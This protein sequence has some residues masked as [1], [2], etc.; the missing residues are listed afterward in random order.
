M[1]YTSL[2]TPAVVSRRVR[3]LE[4]I[5]LKRIAGK[6][7]RY[8]RRYYCRVLD[9]ALERYS[10]ALTLLATLTCPF[11]G[12]QMTRKGILTRHLKLYHRSEWY[13]L[14]REISEVCTQPS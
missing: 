9:C 2:N 10:D 5:V 11:C 14:L 3:K 8:N 12:T 4:G 7:W 1:V 13:D 6:T